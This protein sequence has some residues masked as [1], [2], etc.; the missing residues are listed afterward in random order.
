MYRWILLAAA[1]LPCLLGL[2]GRAAAADITLVSPGAV[3][4]SLAELI[5]RFEQSSGH[6]VA[7]KYSP[8]L[9]LAER[10]KKGEG[11]DVAILG[12]PAADALAKE[13]RLVAGSKVVIATVGVGVFVRRGAPKRLSTRS[14]AR[15]W[16]HKPSLIPIR[17]VA[18][19]RPTMWADS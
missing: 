5:P 9:A 1:L 15:S 2:P 4:T 14:C 8:A 16:T 7:V 18:A 10:I 11:A 3:S 6:K 19:L 12:E 13:G 17:R